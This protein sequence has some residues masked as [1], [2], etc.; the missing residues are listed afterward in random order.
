[1]NE[2]PPLFDFEVAFDI[3]YCKLRVKYKAKCKSVNNKGIKRN[4]LE[5]SRRR[6]SRF[7]GRGKK[8]L[9]FGEDTE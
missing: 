4:V 5:K 9:H 7:I 6:K 3:T 2:K 8:R 1:M